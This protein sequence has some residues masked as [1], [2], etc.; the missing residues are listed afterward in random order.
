MLAVAQQYAP[1]EIE[2]LTAGYFG[3]PFYSIEGAHTGTPVPLYSV[4]PD[5]DVSRT[6]LS[7]IDPVVRFYTVPVLNNQGEILG[8]YRLNLTEREGW[9]FA[10][11]NR[12]G[13][14]TRDL[15]AK[16]V[17][18]VS[19]DSTTTL[20]VSGTIW[21][22]VTSGA[23]ERGVAMSVPGGD[24][25]WRTAPIAGRVYEGTALRHWFTP[26]TRR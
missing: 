2:Q 1:L 23:V 10:S 6:L 11:A 3:E 14:L 7:R 12:E 8:E 16:T 5:A 4:E 26:Q 9:R 24:H 17:L 15:E 13:A 22:V 25:V 18:D 19:S 21:S 20:I